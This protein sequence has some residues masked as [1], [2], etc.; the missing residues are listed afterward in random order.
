MHA[1]KQTNLPEKLYFTKYKKVLQASNLMSLGLPDG[2]NVSIKTL[3]HGCVYMQCMLVS[4]EYMVIPIQ[5]VSFVC[6]YT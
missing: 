5:T 4:V 1:H 6:F 3:R 2:D